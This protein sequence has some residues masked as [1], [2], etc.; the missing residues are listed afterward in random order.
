[1]YA[2]WSV[3]TPLHAR[4]NPNNYEMHRVAKVKTISLK[5]KDEKLNKRKLNYDNTIEGE[6]TAD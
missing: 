6:Y 1:M 3:C 5:R 2:C 4:L